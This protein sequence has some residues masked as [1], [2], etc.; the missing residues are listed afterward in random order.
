ML[1]LDA[2]EPTVDEGEA[3]NGG[4]SSVKP[5]GA[6]EGNA[7]ARRPTPSPL[8]SLHV[9]DELDAAEP[10]EQTREGG[11]QRG[12]RNRGSRA[13]AVARVSFPGAAREREEA[14]G[15][16]RERGGGGS[17][18]GACYAARGGTTE[19]GRRGPRAAG[20]VDDRG[21]PVDDDDF[22]E[23]PLEQEK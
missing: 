16:G 14:H 19:L 12:G 10:E 9:E 13:A 17:T 18:R 3:E 22:A 1:T 21:I 20:A 15:G 6:E 11:E 7:A 2:W 5:A 23:N 8:D 4:D